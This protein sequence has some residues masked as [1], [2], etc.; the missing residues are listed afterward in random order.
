[1][2]I[3]KSEIE[4]FSEELLEYGYYDPFRIDQADIA[5]LMKLNDIVSEDAAYSHNFTEEDEKRLTDTLE[6]DWDNLDIAKL[7]ITSSEHIEASKVE[8]ALKHR[9]ICKVWRNF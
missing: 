6:N 3:R 7:Y 5:E 9:N 1:M 2:A 4:W 8:K